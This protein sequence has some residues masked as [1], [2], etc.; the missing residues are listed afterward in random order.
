[1]DGKF[2]VFGHVIQGMDV[3][4]NLTPRDPSQSG[5]L[6]PGDKILSVSIEEK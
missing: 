1:L 6:P 2:S 3:A 4:T 5:D